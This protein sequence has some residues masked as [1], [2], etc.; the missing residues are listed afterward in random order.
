MLA[1]DE[2]VSKYSSILVVVDMQKDF[3][4]GPLGNEDCMKAVPNVVNAVESG[5][6]DA[7]F[8]TKDA[9][10]E[11]YMERHDAALMTMESCH[12]DVVR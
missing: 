4:T 12:I 9:H 2:K 8:V 7:I 3:I 6:Y 1:T 5:N 11:D 10:G